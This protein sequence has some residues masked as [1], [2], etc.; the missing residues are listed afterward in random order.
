MYSTK[1]ADHQHR[2]PVAHVNACHV[3]AHNP[4]D[5]EAYH[6]LLPFQPQAHCCLT[7]VLTLVEG[8]MQARALELMHCLQYELDLLFVKAAFARC[9]LAGNQHVLGLR[10]DR[11]D[12]VSQD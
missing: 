8:V 11:C 1:N 4:S 3:T 12:W 5:A 9:G 6:C 7:L 10:A 2:Q